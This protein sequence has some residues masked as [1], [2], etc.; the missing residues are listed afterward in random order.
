[1][2]LPYY[3]ETFLKSDTFPNSYAIFIRQIIAKGSL[4]EGVL[5]ACF[6]HGGWQAKRRRSGA[7]KRGRRSGI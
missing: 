1:M 5:L 4:F 7:R 6:P 3:G 2:R